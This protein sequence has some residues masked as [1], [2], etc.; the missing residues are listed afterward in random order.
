MPAIG[1]QARVH[2]A[3]E[4]GFFRVR[5]AKV[6]AAGI[7]SSIL[8]NRRT[9]STHTSVCYGVSDAQGRVRLVGIP[10]H[11]VSVQVTA[12]DHY[13][14]QVDYLNRYT[15]LV[16]T[17]EKGGQLAGTVLD[18]DGKPVDKARVYVYSES[19]SRSTTQTTKEDGKFEVSLA[20]KGRF[21]IRYYAKSEGDSSYTYEFSKIM[22][23]PRQDLV[24]QFGK[25]A[26]DDRGN[27][28]ARV[29]AANIGGAATAIARSTWCVMVMASC[30]GGGFV[31][32][33]SEN[34]G[35]VSPFRTPICSCSR[36]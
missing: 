27:P 12:K 5:R 28:I 8:V 3:H 2:V 22:R 23:E 19:S 34:S 9:R 11:G 15:P 29:A 35:E 17:L 10:T 25:G 18:V 33:R 26:V 32:G 13:G 21:R 14:W 20:A 4:L 16:A 36:E 6:T 31:G 30:G 1:Q 24:L 7:L